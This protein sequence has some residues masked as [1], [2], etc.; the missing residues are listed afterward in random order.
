MSGAAPAR[1][2]LF[3]ALWPDEAARGKLAAWARGAHAVA[4]GRAMR[5]QNLHLTL[6]FL[7][8]VAGERVRGL[9]AMPAPA[10]RRFELTLDCAGYWPRNRIVWAGAAAPPPALEALAAGLRERLDGAGQPYDPK[11][12]VPH[13]TLLREARRASLPAFAPVAWPVTEVVL[14]QSVPGADYAI[15]ARSPLSRAA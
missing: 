13:V 8:N 15:L 6:A 10:V 3:F 11:P 14:V 9:A 1:L 5:P 2:R 7:G 4:G 12:F